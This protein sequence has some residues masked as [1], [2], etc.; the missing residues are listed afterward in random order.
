M[1]K[2]AFKHAHNE[3]PDQPVH[4]HRTDQS[5]TCPPNKKTIK[6]AYSVTMNIFRKKIFSF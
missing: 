3:G 2:R 4:P 5:L 6:A 1:T